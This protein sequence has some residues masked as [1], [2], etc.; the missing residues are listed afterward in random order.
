MAQTSDWA[1]QEEV[2]V[3]EA[4]EEVGGD[5]EATGSSNEW[6]GTEE[7]VEEGEGDLADGG[8]LEPPEEAKLFVGNLPYDVD[9]ERL[10]KILEPAGCVEIAEVK[11]PLL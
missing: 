2:Q 8:V 9:S 6:G 4:E 7:G 11:S 5:I 1:R 3:N 10:A